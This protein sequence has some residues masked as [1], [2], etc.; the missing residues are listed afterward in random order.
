MLANANPLESPALV[1][2]LSASH[3]TGQTELDAR[4]CNFVAAFGWTRQQAFRAAYRDVRK[5]INVEDADR[6]YMHYRHTSELP[7]YVLAY[8][9]GSLA[10]EAP[11]P[12]FR[13]VRRPSTA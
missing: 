6:H 4:F 11:Q 10:T 1:G 12:R 2:A 13:Q 7:D 5:A 9:D 8:M 3:R